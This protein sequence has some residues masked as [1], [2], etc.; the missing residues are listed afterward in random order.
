MISNQEITLEQEILGGL[1]HN[2]SLLVKAKEIIKPQ[3][4]SV[5]AHRLIY[6]SF[7]DMRTEGFE[8]DLINFLEHYKDKTKDFGGI[9][10]VTEIATSSASESNYESKLKIL[11][12]NFKRH[13]IKSLIPRL[14]NENELNELTKTL[15]DT[16][17]TVYESEVFENIDI[18]SKYE[19]YLN[20]IYEEEKDT[21]Y[22]SGLIALDNA[23]GNF[24]KGRLITLFARS[25]VGKSTVAIEIALN[26]S[27][28]G[29]KVVYASGEMGEHEVL[30]KMAASKLNI[31]Y[32]KIINKKLEEN[33]KEKIMGLSTRLLNNSF[34]ITNETNINRLINEIKSYKLQYG[35]DVLFVDYVNKYTNG[36]E[37]NSLS[38][39]IGVI[40]STLKDLALKENIC[41]V[42]LAQCNRVADKNTGDYMSDKIT[43]ADIQ[44]SA[45]IEQDSDQLVALY[46]NKKLDDPV[47]RQA[48]YQE[49]KLDYHSKMADKNPYC[50]NLII[51]KNRHGKRGT[52]VF[53]WDGEHSRVSNF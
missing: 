43:E 44:D 35:L 5:L 52:L 17:K 33:D 2:N 42:L 36:V 11:V 49:G 4:F 48:M 38:E 22:K 28:Q 7:M 51:C 14:T 50:I 27:I 32:S 20:W 15:E 26:I 6:K 30:G 46:R 45:R 31:P 19:K 1:F 23:L 16:L 41:V 29:H 39:K 34:H 8:I 47:T 10:Y 40:T 3:M 53:K 13:K 25:G 9:T 12:N 18:C 21:G 24:Q 37:G